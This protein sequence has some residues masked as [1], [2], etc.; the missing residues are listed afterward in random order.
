MVGLTLLELRVVKNHPRYHVQHHLSL[1]CFRIYTDT[2]DLTDWQAI[3]IIAD[4]K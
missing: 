1:D 2:L 4:V 3:D